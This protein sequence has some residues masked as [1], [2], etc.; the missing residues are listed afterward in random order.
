MLELYWT[1]CG[2]ELPQIVYQPNLRDIVS[3]LLCAI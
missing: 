1:L 3:S 2:F